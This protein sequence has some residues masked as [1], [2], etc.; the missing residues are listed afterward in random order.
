MHLIIEEGRFL[1]SGSVESFETRLGTLRSGRASVAMLHGISVEYYGTPTPIEQIA[2]LS[3]VEG[4]QLLIKPFDRSSIKDMERALNESHLGLPVQSDGSVLR[5]NIPQLTEQVR[6][7]VAKQVSVYAE[8]AKV[9]I[10]N[11][12]R[13]L[14]DDVKKLDDVTEDQE[15]SLLEDVQKITDEFVKKIDEIAKAKSAEILSI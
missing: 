6:K 2:Q 1:M 8:E 12:R 15:R 14:N 4:R 10:R 11:I 7:D 13:D 5:I 9:A 3:V